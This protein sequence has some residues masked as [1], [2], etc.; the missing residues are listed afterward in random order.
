MYKR[1]ETNKS[2]AKKTG[3]SVGTIGR[4]KANGVRE[5][6]QA[7]AI[8]YALECDHREVLEDNLYKEGW[9]LLPC[10]PGLD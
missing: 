8:A 6:H 5:R 7:Y 3:F 10:L 1:G 4:W 2:M 9:D